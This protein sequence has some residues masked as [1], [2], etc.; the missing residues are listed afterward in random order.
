MSTV[1]IEKAS[2]ELFGQYVSRGTIY[3]TLVK[4][5]IP[6]R[7]KSV[8]VQRAMSTLDI[9]RSFINEET[10][11][12]I[13]GLMLGD[14]YM[15]FKKPSHQN[16]RI[17]IGTS[18]K[19]WAK[20]AMSRLTDYNPCVPTVYQKVD[21]KH[22]NPIWECK[23]KTHP[24]LVFQAKRWYCGKNETKVVPED[25]RITPN[26]VM[27]WYL[28]DGSLTRIK[29]NN[30]YFVRMATCS[31][32]VD[33]VDQILIPK[34]ESYNIKCGKDRSKN[35]IVI[36]GGSIRNFFDFIGWQSPFS[37]YDHTF[38]IPEWLKLYR[39]SDITT[40]QKEKWRIQK[41]CKEGKVG[42]SKSPGGK[43]LLFTR[44]QA[45]KVRSILV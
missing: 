3:K 12:W 34:L 27:L 2:L 1:D 5:E 37:D 7:S 25:I 11:E 26:S 9:D 6:C 14:G 28:G 33:H 38:A 40:D 36:Y 18:S 30:A 21:A 19:Q 42:H 22:P 29:K 32:H 44:E 4:N 16:S 17:I 15:N 35:D 43:M 45:N 10:I 13:D 41:A 24:D 39:L 31:F 8:S 20:Y 23:T